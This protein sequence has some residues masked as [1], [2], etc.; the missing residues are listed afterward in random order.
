MPDEPQ[1]EPSLSV[2]LTQL[3]LLYPDGTH[4]R[5]T[6][7]HTASLHCDKHEPAGLDEGPLV[8]LR[9]R[10]MDD[11][12]KAPNSANALSSLTRAIA[13]IRRANAKLPVSPRNEAAPAPLPSPP[14][15]SAAKPES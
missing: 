12:D 3:A 9:Q 13:A 15:S 8:A 6:L 11:I 10:I 7:L 5:H 14:Q 2:A 4:A 1:A